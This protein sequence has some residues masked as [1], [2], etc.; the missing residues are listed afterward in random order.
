M[1]ARI[2][3]QSLTAV[4]TYPSKAA[5]A[6]AMGVSYNALTEAINR[7]GQCAGMWWRE[8]DPVIPQFYQQPKSIRVTRDDGVV[9]KSIKS[10]VNAYFIDS[11]PDKAQWHREYMALSRAMRRGKPWRGHSYCREDMRKV[12]AA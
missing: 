6:D 4:E 12:F 2:M 9:F 1:N 5:A 7:G 10:A 8:I 3:V 11:I